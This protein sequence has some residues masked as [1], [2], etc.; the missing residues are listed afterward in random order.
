MNFNHLFDTERKDKNNTED[1]DKFLSRVFGIFNEEIVRIWCNREDSPLEDIGRPTIRKIGD[2]SRGSTLDFTF[3]DKKTK[4]I[5]VS[6]MKCEI[7]YRNYSYL[8][9][10]NVEQI[11]RHKKA[12]FNRFLQ[13]A[14]NPANYEVKIGGELI[15]E[16]KG[17]ILVWGKISESKK[18]S[19]LEKTKLKDVLSVENIINDLIE[20]K[21]ENYFQLLVEKQ[22]WMGHLFRGLQT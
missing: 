16:V 15:K 17:A 8:E 10:R 7:Q 5:Y 14:V 4:N 13:I 11:N 19:I 22:E 12:A 3:Q 18:A 9:L 21:D 6:E 1:R 20:K 2:S